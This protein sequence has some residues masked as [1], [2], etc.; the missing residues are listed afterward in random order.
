MFLDILPSVP[1]VP[2]FTGPNDD[3]SR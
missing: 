2:A 3:R 1:G